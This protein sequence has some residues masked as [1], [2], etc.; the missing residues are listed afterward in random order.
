[1]SNLAALIVLILVFVVRSRCRLYVIYIIHIR[2]NIQ[3]RSAV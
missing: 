1:M 3:F 2:C